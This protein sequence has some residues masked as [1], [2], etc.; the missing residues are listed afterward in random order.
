MKITIPSRIG[1]PTAP[2]GS[3]ADNDGDRAAASVTAAAATDNAAAAQPSISGSNLKLPASSS[4]TPGFSNPPPSISKMTI[5]AT[6]SA[7]VEAQ[8]GQKRKRASATPQAVSIPVA[9]AAVSN[10]K[11]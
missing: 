9:V 5:P 10:E 1:V 2:P 7:A 8:A 11:Q 6:P 3:R 4:S